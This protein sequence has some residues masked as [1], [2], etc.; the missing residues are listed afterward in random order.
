MESEADY[1]YIH[2]LSHIVPEFLKVG[3]LREAH[4]LTRSGFDQEHVTPFLRKNKSL[5]KL[6]ELP[7]DFE[8]LRP[9]LDPYLT[10][11][12]GEQL[13]AFEKMSETLG[14]CTCS[15]LLTSRRR[16]LHLFSRKDKGYRQR[17][18]PTAFVAPP[19]TRQNV[20]KSR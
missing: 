18:G 6:N 5:F 19:R 7:N 8:G 9:E 2:G 3:A 12:T 15:L 11:D 16:N 20:P 17:Q 14:Q 10:I 1:T 4:E 13:E